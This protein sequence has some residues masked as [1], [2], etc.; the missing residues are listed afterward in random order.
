MATRGIRL[1]LYFCPC[2]QFIGQ[3]RP[4]DRQIDFHS[5]INCGHGFSLGPRGVTLMSGQNDLGTASGI[6]GV[7]GQPLYPHGRSLSAQDAS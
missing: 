7:C 2:S 6:P 1:L 3:T 5:Q 4:Q